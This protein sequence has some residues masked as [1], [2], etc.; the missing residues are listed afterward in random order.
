[1]GRLGETLLDK[2]ISKIKLI[3]V[4]LLVEPNI[5]KVVKEL[6]QLAKCSLRD[7]Q[8]YFH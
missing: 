7:F 3:F 2:A 8:V 4:L 5:S 1:M 6:Q